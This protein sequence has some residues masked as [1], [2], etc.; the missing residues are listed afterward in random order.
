M[1]DSRALH[2]K[3]SRDNALPLVL[4]LRLVRAFS[5]PG[6]HVVDPF[7]GSGTI[8]VAC[9]LTSRRC[10]SGDVNPAAVAFAGARLLDEHAWPDERSPGLFP[11]PA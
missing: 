10:T 8:P 4:A 7:T 3:R 9:Y 6:R 11:R 2:L 5:D 1:P